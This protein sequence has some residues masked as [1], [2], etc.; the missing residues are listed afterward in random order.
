MRSKMEHAINHY[1]LIGVGEEIFGALTVE[2][3]DR[4]KAKREGKSE[5][6]NKPKNHSI[7][8]KIT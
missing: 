5:D 7:L 4:V 8:P 2:F 3:E 6:K 1:T